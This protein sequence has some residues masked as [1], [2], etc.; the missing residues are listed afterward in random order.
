MNYRASAL[1]PL[2]KNIASL[3]YPC[4]A[5]AAAD[6]REGFKMSMLEMYR[7]KT[8]KFIVR[9]YIEADCDVDASFDETGETQDK[10]NSGEYEAFGTVVEVLTATGIKLGESSLWGSIYERPA[11]FFKEHIGLAA[12]SRADGCNYGSYF[13]GMV[14]EAITEARKAIAAMP[15]VRKTEA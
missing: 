14:R 15:A 9:A 12:K 6:N 5:V 1:L 13:P 11:D 2:D 3:S 7:F 4:M 8:A 10:L